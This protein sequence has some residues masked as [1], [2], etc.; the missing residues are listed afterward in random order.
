MVSVRAVASLPI[1]NVPLEP[2]PT[3]SELIEAPTSSVTVC[4]LAI[5]TS[6]LAVGGTPLSQVAPVFQFPVCT[7]MYETA[8]M[9]A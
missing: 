8:G 5:V 2:C 1:I 7:D 9:V 4:P 6:A 3:V